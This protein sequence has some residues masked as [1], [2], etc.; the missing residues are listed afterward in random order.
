MGL[1]NPGATCH[2]SALLGTPAL[3]PPTGSPL[4]YRSQEGIWLAWASAAISAQPSSDLG[5]ID[6]LGTG[7]HPCL[8]DKARVAGTELGPRSARVP[9]RQVSWKSWGPA[10]RVCPP[11]LALDPWPP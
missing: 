11:T 3:F 7:G 6:C 1:C 9:G 10:G 8:G 5:M 4:S 2:N